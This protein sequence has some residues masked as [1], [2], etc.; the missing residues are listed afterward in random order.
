MGVL[1]NVGCRRRRRVGGGGGCRSNVRALV[2]EAEGLFS[3]RSG[4]TCAVQR[5]LSGWISQHVESTDLRTRLDE[6]ESMVAA[7][8]L[9]IP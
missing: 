6:T 3:F 8:E 1:L 2:V 9:V 7:T 4:W 5:V